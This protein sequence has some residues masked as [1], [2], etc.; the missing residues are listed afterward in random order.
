MRLVGLTAIVLLV[1]AMILS[2][3]HFWGL[4]QMPKAFDHPWYKVP[5]PWRVVPLRFLEKSINSDFIWIDVVRSVE[6]NL[7]AVTK[8]ID[9]SKKN[10]SD[11]EL[12]GHGFAQL[13]DGLAQT[14]DRNVVLNLVTNADGIDLQISDLIGTSGKD[15]IMIQSEYDILM[16]SI[17]KL[18]PLWLY[19]SS[20]GERVR[21]RTFESLWILP[22]TPFQGDIYVGPFRQKNVELLTEKVAQELKRR[23][24]KMIIGPVQTLDDY[25]LALRLGADGVFIDQE[26]VLGLTSGL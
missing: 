7:Y 10:W 4:S 19:G 5:R 11:Q 26:E 16:R 6:Q 1:L 21:F 3:A 18:Q 8:P 14:R 17:K 13:K 22:A 2:S 12:A 24:H 25:N 23:G 15:R 20:Q 9:F